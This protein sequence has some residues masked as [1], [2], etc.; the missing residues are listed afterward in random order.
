M[1][2]FSYKTEFTVKWKTSTTTKKPFTSSAN[3]IFLNIFGEMPRIPTYWKV[4][5]DAFTVNTYGFFGLSNPY[6]L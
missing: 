5:R 2:V 3:N 6:G 1:A 4:T